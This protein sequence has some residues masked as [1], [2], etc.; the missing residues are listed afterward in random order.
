M[1]VKVTM[2]FL[3]HHLASTKNWPANARDPFPGSG[4]FPGGRN[5]NPLQ[6]SCLGDLMDRGIRQARVHV[7][8]KEL[9]MI[10]CL[11][12]SKNLIICA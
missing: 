11:N 10:W 2:A 12:N 3:Q 4:R 7:V 8:T 5:G 1:K 6:Y 9:D